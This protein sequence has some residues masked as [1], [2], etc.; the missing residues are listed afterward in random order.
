M[1]GSVPNFNRGAVVAIMMLLPSIISILI[2]GYLDR[3][4]IRYS[5]VSDIEKK[6]H[7]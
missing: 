4:N 1:L 2:L 7:V 3:Y 5:K 6:S